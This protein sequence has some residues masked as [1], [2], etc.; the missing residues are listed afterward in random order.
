MHQ[1]NARHYLRWANKQLLCLIKTSNTSYSGHWNKWYEPPHDITNKMDVRP[2]KAQISLGIRPV[3]SESL[4]SAWRKLGSL[5]NH[6]AHSE[7]SDQT[8]QAYLSLRWAHTHFVGFVM[9]R[10]IWTIMIGHWA[11]RP[12]YHEA[13]EMTFSLKCRHSQCV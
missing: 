2:A 4:L 10:L 13:V 9:S 12:Q 11:A 1:S 3:W 8:A 5:A 7:D 6:Q